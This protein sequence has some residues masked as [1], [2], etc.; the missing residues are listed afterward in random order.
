MYIDTRTVKPFFMSDSTASSMRLIASAHTGV[1]HD[2]G[3]CRHDQATVGQA[4]CGMTSH[5]SLTERAVTRA[6]GNKID[7]DK[8]R[9][10]HIHAQTVYTHTC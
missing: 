7:T 4:L 1:P 9:L 3:V 5:G 10:M 6:T 8:H 2:A